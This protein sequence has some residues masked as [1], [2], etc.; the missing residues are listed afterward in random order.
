[1]DTTANGT[2]YTGGYREGANEG[3]SF[4]VLFGPLANLIQGIGDSVNRILQ[5]LIIGEDTP[6]FYNS[7]VF[8]SE[9]VLKIIT[10][11]PT[12]SGVE[13]VE[14]VKD[15]IDTFTGK[16]GVP[17]IK[18]TPAEIFAGNVSALDANFLKQKQITVMNWV[19]MENQ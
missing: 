16:Y 8:S 4:G 14:V 15:Y 5:S 2:G 11:N 18:L 17:D 1:M 12:V 13:T 3:D 19:E 7:G 6:V 9:K 10:D